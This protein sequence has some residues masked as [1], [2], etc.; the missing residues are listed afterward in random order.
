MALT[1]LQIQKLLPKTNCKECDCNTCLAFAM[2][3]AAKKAELSECPYV[4]EEAKAIVGAAA[5]PPVRTVT[6][7][8]GADGLTAGGETVMFRH[9]KTFVHQTGL[10]LAI[11]DTLDDSVLEERVKALGDY[12]LERVGEI[13][14]PDLLSVAYVSGSRERFLQV[15]EKAASIFSPPVIVGGLL[16]DERIGSFFNLNGGTSD[17]YRLV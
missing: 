6:L 1:G 8:E 15:C 5:E 14:V 16:Y 9:E 17:S 4:S 3:L 7:G 12:E 13:L 2:K 11:D 10:G